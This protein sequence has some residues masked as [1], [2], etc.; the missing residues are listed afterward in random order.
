VVAQHV[1]SSPPPSDATLGVVWRSTALRLTSRR[2][3]ILLG[4]GIAG[5]AASGLTRRF[6]VFAAFGIVVSA[7]ACYA[8]LIQPRGDHDVHANMRRRLAQL[9]STIAALAALTAGLL[10]LAAIFGG[11]IEVMR[12]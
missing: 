1:G 4:L 5:V 11:A 3:A 6:P 9:A 8:V 12:H 10:M 2:I 7:F